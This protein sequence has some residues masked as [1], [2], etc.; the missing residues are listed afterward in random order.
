MVSVL[1]GLYGTVLCCLAKLPHYE[2]QNLKTVRDSQP[3]EMPSSSSPV[4]W[5]RCVLL[6]RDLWTRLPP[7]GSLNSVVIQIKSFFS[8]LSPSSLML[9]S[10]QSAV[11]CA[12]FKIPVNDA[13]TM[14]PVDFSFYFHCFSPENFCPSDETFSSIFFPACPWLLNE[15]FSSSF[16][17]HGS[18]FTIQTRHNGLGLDKQGAG[19][20]CLLSI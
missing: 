10:S 7:L 13:V 6:W 15:A 20:L 19:L 14:L 11:E 2:G 1:R 9:P 12:H 5:L 8:V 4:L 16:Q 17:I 18:P 3:F